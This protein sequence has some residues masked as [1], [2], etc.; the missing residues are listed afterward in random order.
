MLEG[1]YHGGRVRFAVAGGVALGLAVLAHHMT[2]F[3]LAL[4]LPAWVVY[5]YLCQP[6]PRRHLYRVTLLFGVAT[7]ATTLWWIAPWAANLLEAGFQRET[8]GL[9]SFPLVQYLKAINQ[10]ELIGFYAYPIYLGIGLITMCIGGTIQAMVSPSRSTPYAVLLLLLV[11]FSLG[12]QVNPLLRVRPLDGLDVARFQL[13]MVPIIAVVG[14]PFLATVGTAV[15]ELLRLGKP[16]G[17]LPAAIGG[18]LVALLLGQAVWDGAVASQRLFQPYQVTPATRQALDW[19]GQEGRHGKVLGVGF[20][21]WDDFL[22]PYYLGQAVVDG[23][24]NEGA[25]NWRTVRPLRIM[26]WSGEVD[27]PRAHQLLRELD[28]Q[29]IAVQD[30]FEGESPDKFRAALRKHPGLFSEVADWGEV[31]IF[32]WIPQG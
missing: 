9:W 10:R 20:W 24:H 17:W 32:E 7:A 3:A 16:P 15:V 5:Y 25:R 18:I 19:F 14:L 31:T 30:Y 4:R 6:V 11:A 27:I 12:E 28:G 21:H 2:A 26:M 1:A 8:P 29:Y 23:W 22:L 13:Y